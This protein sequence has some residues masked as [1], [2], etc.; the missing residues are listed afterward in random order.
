MT[1]FSMLRPA[2]ATIGVIGLIIG[3][4]SAALGQDDVFVTNRESVQAFLNSDGSLDVARVYDQVDA[5]GS[6][7]VRIENP[8]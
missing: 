6:G 7:T 1:R 2:A 5:F 8:V 4:A 3:P